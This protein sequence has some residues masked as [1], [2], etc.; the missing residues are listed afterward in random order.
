MTNRK[1]S[2]DLSKEQILESIGRIVSEG[3]SRGRSA[4]AGAATLAPPSPPPAPKPSGGDDVLDL[5]DVVDEQGNV[6]QRGQAAEGA[7]AFSF[8]PS[9]ERPPRPTGEGSKATD[10][11]MLEALRP[12]LQTWLDTHMPPIVERLVQRELERATRRSEPE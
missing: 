10:E 9:G 7:P 8:P 11:Q 2:D 1:P 3:E 5:V 12:M 4:D 6:I